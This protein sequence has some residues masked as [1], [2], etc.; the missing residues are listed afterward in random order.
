MSYQIKFS[1]LSKTTDVIVPDM[2][3]GINTVDTS[4]S[5]VGKGYPNYGEK[6]AENFLHLLENFASPLPPENPIEGQLWYDTSNQSRKVLRIMDGTADTVRWP[7]ANGI[8]QQGTDPRNYSN[9]AIKVGDIWVDTSSN[10]LKIYG[11]GDWTVVGP[12]SGS[13]E[14]KTGSESV[15]LQDATTP[16]VYHSVVLNWA[17]GQVVS[18]ESSDAEFK[19]KI[20]ISGMEGFKTIKPGIT[21]KP[22]DATQ[23]NKSYMLNG[24][25]YAS[26]NLEISGQTYS[27]D[28]VLIKDSP[29]GQVITSRVIF[30][31]NAGIAF[32]TNGTSTEY[33]LYKSANDVVL[34]NLISGGKIIFDTKDAQTNTI[35]DTVI[36]SR[37][38]VGINTATNSISSKP[39]LDVYGSAR[40]LSTLTVGKVLAEQDIMVTNNAN[41]LGNLNVGGITSCTSEVNVGSSVGS[42]PIIV[43]NRHDSYDIGSSTNYFRTLYV[44]S[45]VSPSNGI[46]IYG[47]IKGSASS[48]ESST[49]FKMQGQATSPSFLFNGNGTPAVFDVSLTRN[50]INDQESITSAQPT[51]T[52]LVLNTSTSSTNLQKI[53]KKEFLK[54]LVPSGVV[55]LYGGTSVPTGWLACDNGLYSVTDYPELYAIIGNQYGGAPAGT[56]RV[57]AISNVGLLIYII[58]T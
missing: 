6:I 51:H 14:S 8:Y 12:S 42:G 58:K 15:K 20:L 47:T 40:I 21:L 56:F 52:L 33:Q 7:L 50:A 53:S 29:F 13:F 45:I 2:P 3:P 48:L 25:S 24:T 55:M 1:D 46:S 43:P 32:A 5:L 10:Q 26:Q 19:P 41:I 11:S 4:L 30:S 36:V 35:H 18:I 22:K 28:R 27:A 16:T 44:S 34:S 39:L 9:A 23:V 31:S 17:N 49:E 37:N 38:F 57:P 54:D